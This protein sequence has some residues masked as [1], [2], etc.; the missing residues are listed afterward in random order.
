[1]TTER[2]AHAP[3]HL[4]PRP[5]GRC[6]ADTPHAQVLSNFF[7][8]APA[9]SAILIYAIDSG[10]LSSEGKDAKSRGKQASGQDVMCV[11][12]GVLPDYAGDRRAFFVVKNVVGRVANPYEDID[13]GVIP[14]QSSSAL[15]A[16]ENL[17]KG[18]YAPMLEGG[19]GAGKE[20]AAKATDEGAAKAADDKS[21]EKVPGHSNSD[22]SRRVRQFAGQLASVIQKVSG[23]VKLP[24]PDIVID[25]KDVEKAATDLDTVSKL[26]PTLDEWNNLIVDVLDSELSKKRPVETPLGEIELWKDR[27]AVLSALYEQ[28]TMPRARNLIQVL[29]LAEVLAIDDFKKHLSVLMKRYVEAKDNVKFLSTLERHFKNVETASLS[30][31]LDT[32]PSMMESLRMVWIISR[33]YNR[34]ERMF[35]L[36]QL[37]ASQLADRV[38]REIDVK[39]TLNHRPES[40]AIDKVNLAISVLNQWYTSFSDVKRQIAKDSQNS[41]MQQ[42]NFERKLL[43]DRTTYMVES[44]KRLERMVRV[45]CQFR[46]FLGKELKSVTGDPETIEKVRGEVDA[47]VAPVIKL[48]YS[49]FDARFRKMWKAADERYT[50]HVRTIE[51]QCNNL[52]HES[53]KKEKLESAEEA[54]ELL[55]KFKDIDTLPSIRETMTGKTAEVLRQYLTTVAAVEAEFSRGVENPPRFRN[56]PP[57]AGAIA[58]LRSLFFKIK[59]PILKFIKMKDPPKI[60]EEVKS[61]Y[62][63]IAQKICSYE[64]ATF[65]EWC[66]QA[67]VTMTR[68][69]KDP[70]LESVQVTIGRLSES[71]LKAMEAKKKE[72]KAAASKARDRSAAG[73]SVRGD[74]DVS[75]SMFRSSRHSTSM[76]GSL[77]QSSRLGGSRKSIGSNGTSSI[78]SQRRS[79]VVFPRVT[80]SGEQIVT[81]LRVNF[82]DSLFQLIKETKYLSRLGKKVPDVAFNAALQEQKYN[83]M[84]EQLQMMLEKYEA[85]T[86]KLTAQEREVFARHIQQLHRVLAQGCDR[87]NWTSLGTETFIKKCE[88]EIARFSTMV[89]LVQKKSRMILKNVTEMQNTELIDMRQFV[90][91]GGPLAINAVREI[92]E[93][94]LEAQL[95]KMVKVHK[96]IPQILI[97]MEAD[98]KS[99]GKK[100]A[101][102]SKGASASVTGAKQGLGGGWP[103]PGAHPDMAGYYDYWETCIYNALCTCISR[104]IE[105][106]HRV[107]LGDLEGVSGFD[108]EAPPGPLIAIELRCTSSSP[109][110]QTMPNLGD[111][112]PAVTKLAHNIHECARSFVRWARGTCIA[113]SMWLEGDA[114][115]EIQQ[116]TFQDDVDSNKFLVHQ[117]V[118]FNHY[119]QHVT[120]QANQYIRRW[121]K[122]GAPSFVDTDGRSKKGYD[123]WNSKEFNELESLRTT[124]PATSYF[125]EQLNYYANVKGEVEA[126]TAV[127]DIDFL[128]LNCSPLL[129]TVAK[130]ARDWHERFGDILREIAE[131][132]IYSISDE[133]VGMN[134]DL[135]KAPSGL[136]DTKFVIDTIMRIQAAN[137]EMEVRFPLVQDQFALLDRH[138]FEIKESDA[139]L[140]DGIVDR[141]RDLLLESRKRDARLVLVKKRFKRYTLNRIE[142]FRLMIAKCDEDFEEDGPMIPS[143]EN[144]KLAELKDEKAR[145]KF[146]ARKRKGLIDIDLKYGLS[147]L[148]I[149]RTEIKRLSDLRD[150]YGRCEELFN[151]A[152][153]TY[154]T[155][156]KLE[157][158]MAKLEKVYKLYEEFRAKVESWSLTLWVNLDSKV[159]LKGSKALV[160]TLKSEDYQSLQGIVAFKQLSLEIVG[161]K[162]SVPLFVALKS[163]T[164][165]T[166][167]WKQLEVFSGIPIDLNPKTFNLKVLFAMKLHR[168]KDDI[169]EM[170]NASRGEAGIETSLEEISAYWK[171]IKFGL[172]PYKDDPAK[173]YLLN[174]TTDITLEIED[175]A[176]TLAGMSASPFAGAHSKA[177]RQW[178]HDLNLVNE[179]MSAWRTVQVKWTYLEG[180][181]MDSDDI[182]MQLPQAAKKFERVNDAFKDIMKDTK[183]N[184]FVLRACKAENR[185]ESLQALSKELDQC[186]KKLSDYLESKRCL[187]PRFFF[188]SDDE[189]LSIL[190]SSNPATIQV[191][192]LK[193]F[194]QAK[195]LNFVR[196]NTAVNGMKSTKQEKFNF[197]RVVK[198][199]GKVE[200]WMNAVQD[201]MKAS[202][203]DI[204]KEAVFNYADS[205]RINWVFENLQSV[206][207]SGSQIWWTWQVEDAFQQV[208]KGS[209]HAMKSLAKNL[210]A[211]LNELVDTIRGKLDKQQRRKLNTLIIIDVH[212]RDIVDSFVRDSILDANEFAWESQLRFYWDRKV[213]DIRIRQC[214]GNFSFGYEYM[215]QDGRLVITPLTDRI[216]MTLTQAL[217]FHLGGSPAGPAGTGKTE[218]VK[219]LAKAMGL[220]CVVTNCGEGLDYK[221]MGSIYSGLCQTGNWGCFDE[222]NR[223]NIEVLS[224]VSTQLR[225]IQNAMHAGVKRFEFC[226]KEIQL[227]HTVGFFVTM[228]PG[229]EGRTELPDNL[230]A[231][232]RPITVVRPDLQQICEIMLF[233]E[234]FNSARGLAKKMTVLYKLAEGQ[235]SKQ[236]HYDFGLRALKSVLVMAGG[237]KRAS[238]EFAEDLVLMRALRDMNMPKF[239]Y[240]DV[241]LFGGLIFDL[242]PGESIGRVVNRK[243][244]DAVTTQLE[245]DKYK[246]DDDEVFGKQ[247]DKVMQLYEVMLTRHTTM[248]V[249]PTGG[250]KSLVINTLARAKTTGFGIKTT[251]YPINAKS[252]TL[253]ELYGTMDPVTRDWTDGLISKTFREL[254]QPL[255]EGT[256]ESRYVVFDGDVDALW[257][258]NMNSVMDDNKTLTLP[259]GER[260]QLQDHCKLLFEVGDLQFASPATVSRCGMVYVD[261]KDLRFRPYYYRWMTQ[262]TKDLPHD[263]DDEDD[264]EDGDVKEDAKTAKKAAAEEKP[265]SRRDEQRELL[266]EMFDKYMERL[267]AFVLDGIVDGSMIEGGRLD[268][269]V[270]LTSLAVVKQFCNMY[271]TVLPPNPGE[272]DPKE[273]NPKVMEKAFVFCLTWSIGG[274]LTAAS[275]KRFNDFL[276]EQASGR[277]PGGNLYDYKYDPYKDQWIKWESLVT[278][279]APPQPFEFSKILVATSDTVRYSFLLDKIVRSKMPVLF[280]GESGTAKTVIMKAYMDRELD[281]DKY[282]SMTVNFSSRTSS[283][284]VQNTIMASVEKQTGTN[285]APKGGRK[286][287]IFVDD[288][289]MPYVDKYNTQQP[290]ALLKYVIERGNVFDRTSE[291]PEQIMQKLTIRDLLFS[292]AMAP[293]GGGRNSID[294]RFLSLFNIFSFTFPLKSAL[295]HIYSQIITTFCNAFEK[296]VQDAAAQITPMTL[297]LYEQLGKY[298]KRTPS[299]FHYVFNLRDLSKVYEG[300][301][302]ATP[303]VFQTGPSL[304]RLWR[305]E[306]LRIF[307]DRLITPA[308]QE[309][310][311]R[312]IDDLVAGSFGTDAQTICQEPCLFGDFKNVGDEKM[313][314][315]PQIYQDISDFKLLNRVFMGVLDEHNEDSEEKL[316]LVL[317]KD[318]LTHLVRVHRILKLQRGNALLVGVGGSGKQSLAK[319]AAWTAGY[320][321]FQISLTRSYGEEDF[322]EDLKRLYDLLGS[323]D[324]GRPVVFLFTDAH[325]KDENFLEMINNMLTSG[326]VPALFS[327][328]EKAPLIDAVTKECKAKGIMPNRENCWNYFV[329]KCRNNL[330][331]VLC[332]SPSGDTLRVRCRNFPGLISNTSIDWF[333]PWPHSALEVVASHFL[334]E[335]KLPEEHRPKIVA[336]MVFVHLK[337]QEYSE[338]FR[339][340]LRRSNSVT[341]KNYLDYINAYR[342]TLKDKLGENERLYK[343]LDDGLGKLAQ[344]EQDVG[345]LQEDI[346]K[347]K[348][349]V[350][351]ASIKTEDL[352]KNIEV[353]SKKANEEKVIGIQLE[354]E[355]TVKQKQIEIDREA[356]NKDLAAA[357]PVLQRAADALEELKKNKDAI[358]QL[359]SFKNPPGDVKKVLDCVM[360][361]R[362]LDSAVPGGGWAAAKTMMTDGK[363]LHSLVT[364]KRDE[365][366]SKWVKGVKKI[367]ATSSALKDVNSMKS[368]S[369]AAAAMLQWVLAILEYHTVALT[370]QPK[371]DRVARMEQEAF[372][373]ATK[374]RKTK[375]NIKKL[376]EEIKTKNKELD[377]AQTKL[378]ALKKKQAQMAAHL[379]AAEQL[380]SGLANSK[381]RWIEERAMFKSRSALLV[382]DCLISAAFLSYAG[383]FTF[384]YRQSMIYDD[385][386]RHLEE[387]KVPLSENFKVSN[388]L[389]SGVERS[390]WR[391]E[392][393]PPDDLSIQNGILTTRSTRFPLCIDP[394]LQ[395]SKWIKQREKKINAKTLQISS[396]RDDGFMKKLESCVQYGYAFIFDNVNE[397]IDPIINPI[398]EK[399][400]TEKN[401]Q[402]FIQLGDNEVTW[403]DKFRLYLIT[404]LGNPRYSP[405][406]AGRTMIINY[407]VTQGGLEDQLLDVVIGNERP[408]LQQQS[409]ELVQL[410]SKNNILL[411]QL[412]DSILTDL[413]NSD[414]DILENKV[415]IKSLQEAQ[416]KSILISRDLK[417]SQATQ[418]KILKTTSLYRP[419]AKR[420]SVLFFSLSSLSEIS[421]MYEFSLSSYLVVF[422]KALQDSARSNDID[423]RVVN[424]IDRLTEDVYDYVC[425]GIFEK[426]KLMYSAQM[427]FMIMKGEELLGNPEELDFFLKGNISLDVI[428][429]PPPGPWVSKAGW[430]DLH[431]LKKIP[432]FE[433]ILTDLSKNLSQ[434]EAW[435]QLE[436]P[437]KAPMPC[438][439]S[440]KLSP[441]QQMLV[442]RCLR[443]DR[444]TNGLRNFVVSEM[445]SSKFVTPPVLE[446]DRIFRQSSNVTPVVFILSPGADPGGDLQTLARKL[447]FFPNK[448]KELA[449][450]Q[451]QAKEAQSLLNAG[452]AKGHWVILQNCHL[453]ASWL[454]TL[455]KWLEGISAKTPHKDFRLWLTTDPTPNFP[456]S[457]LQMSLKVVTEPPDG[458]KLNMQGSYSKITQADLDECPHEAY[459]PLVYVLSF[460][461][462]VVQERRK[463]GKVGWNVAYDFNDSDFSVSKRL[464]SMYLTKSYDNG[465]ENMPWGSLRYLVGQAMY[466]GRVTDDYDR[467][468]LV[469]YLQE[470]M[471]DFLFDDCQP[472]F[473]ARTENFNYKVPDTGD[474]KDYNA[475]IRELPD[476]NSPVVFG[477]HPNAEIQ[478]NTNMAKTIWTDLIN[479]QPRSTSSG[480]GKTRE[481]YIRETATAL[482]EQVPAPVDLVVTRKVFE[483]IR[484]QEVKEKNRRRREQ[485]KKDRAAASKMGGRGKSPAARKKTPTRRPARRRGA[486]KAGRKSDA[487]QAPKKPKPVGFDMAALLPPTT[488]VLLQELERWNILCLKMAESLDLLLKA[489]KG[490]VGMSQELD[491]LSFALFNGLLPAPWRKLAPGTQKK[492]S[493]WMVHFQKRHAQ[494]SLWLERRK[495]PPVMWLSGLHIPESYLTA[496]IQATCR[497]KGWPLDK[498]VMYTSV[499]KMTD[500]KEVKE[501]PEHGCFI[502]GLYLEGAGWDLESGCL[503]PQKPKVLQEELPILRVTP[504]EAIRLKLQNTFRTPVY[505]TQNRRNAMGVGLVFT[506]DLT[507]DKH[508]SAWVLQGVALCLNIDT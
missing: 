49:I 292:G 48:P 98:L 189:L 116:W 147:R 304:V 24:L 419:S 17:L 14:P 203:R 251:L 194:A 305:H 260:I 110:V 477:L 303:D 362:P 395:A 399:K 38:E 301:C 389:V 50:V 481:D 145:N 329:E 444:V 230:K 418:E 378:T 136:E 407:T 188:I 164:M 289:N 414:S 239:I 371:K 87:L 353:A 373:G 396:F 222:F 1:M 393:L 232:F 26:K 96:D 89:D 363:F 247:V 5:R 320:E 168:F 302:Q 21:D 54:F 291:N 205:K 432:G 119:L 233:S 461:H 75:A 101:K 55:Q 41:G 9:N 224:V 269:L 383:A 423:A 12:G 244:K 264:E 63:Q 398:L 8:E 126:E 426:H 341:P 288:I 163:D 375:S 479:L 111:V 501:K 324:G 360:E 18:V 454:P 82:S 210:T 420:G 241:P 211:Q 220:V 397:E 166:R 430:K 489:L 439:Y 434:W 53:F 184:P 153:A 181:F 183:A 51:D 152:P 105:N 102:K 284:D 361:L 359:K 318:A 155:L 36:L 464:M 16:L 381:V 179:C 505:V 13:Y 127:V 382:G 78:G 231:M 441:L 493:A 261:P 480:G 122:Y 202:L 173:G 45:S 197:K 446:Y 161:F 503:R 468:V 272:K 258:E 436:A 237:L 31:V 369:S 221:A 257:V 308:D 471:G 146:L 175:N 218:T 355:L 97:Q 330:H 370:V 245:R 309:K 204:T 144:K 70:I 182:R 424:I 384:A 66:A 470:Y 246:H 133:I 467:R 91:R 506:A 33:H 29:E 124:V 93:R 15:L 121:D 225:T 139:K 128:Q 448:F 193:L 460:F 170:V 445:K 474:L 394:Q 77:K 108:P 350:D 487:K 57:V 438:E 351:A 409:E 458:L 185:L 99:T 421:P 117:M 169:L 380:I 196:G 263:D 10:R 386:V 326:M 431:R 73:V 342:L 174:D 447:G 300:M 499:T 437:E 259:N 316:N 365:I 488:V 84:V 132:E 408:E 274:C 80:P 455:E 254:N 453:M 60:I 459:R 404:K 290:I 34:E 466:G 11:S 440:D 112:I 200:Q 88:D 253:P 449:L 376:E 273:E 280:T 485:A 482:L 433:S 92:V 27:N 228:N 294:P 469:T 195:R 402:K 314:G 356:A 44:S 32:I 267:L 148:K 172:R 138:K 206:C 177:L 238:P 115:E 346:K 213:D 86:A 311:V 435:Y 331:V 76:R 61:R 157:A 150:E 47:S 412:E 19:R 368:K 450:G 283:L 486:R 28:I 372:R 497:E 490:E 462:A 287:L 212:A 81:R 69:L 180:I 442:L 333:F 120:Q 242:F 240:E 498:S 429:K 23:N 52:I 104:G 271:S 465:D 46:N 463:Y 374:L 159:L 100:P 315:E 118:H 367:I 65:A 507:T 339:V 416:K 243:L 176:M 35:P 40:E 20:A 64:D 123:L 282:Q 327:A 364:Y 167:H 296:P 143:P 279:Y 214:T 478:Y 334:K 72:E 236:H 352:I 103:R 160:K 500:V 293:P 208:R 473:F 7:A 406:V 502:T 171:K 249:G 483:K 422:R 131:K 191:H 268:M 345:K 37:I 379:K 312:C 504:I 484:R 216:Y 201:E 321:I 405:E 392:G 476:V 215:G 475:A 411:K 313:V 234:G 277:T 219:D 492:L 137:N 114:A 22:M 410:I 285:Y 229:Y 298:F 190:G 135:G 95:A 377:E 109:Q 107:L 154:P 223:I 106:L 71:E 125:D 94:N 310:M 343:R 328:E 165:R 142:D 83:G 417:E 30:V 275:R 344:A 56:Q 323:K 252:M 425:T 495:D 209:K 151:I 256:E 322:R 278:P 427:T 472:F 90:T 129:K 338:R 307:N 366:K 306:C 385:F 250:G 67:E 42:W 295:Q 299:K 227:V 347:A 113:T 59:R 158:S 443:Q 317:F 79:S 186:Q 4:H 276:K 388:L 400:Y 198:V 149:F 387:S 456:L 428:E 494:Y 207:L 349:D 141:W 235:L 325:V 354:K 286:L 255:P 508:I 85:V 452:A 217:T 357:E 390:K 265:K 58:W 43:F 337:V 319:L 403:D 74:G 134:R 413:S 281:A 451:G 336:H 415:L 62:K 226:G 178:E 262:R 491:D 25:A 297:G 348:I 391:S 68:R 401:G 2:Y 332:F 156:Y 3:L 6:G 270:P 358:V 266:M 162:E 199:E 335:E 457:I 187:F 130:K 248:V 340:E 39:E 496:L 192:M 140:V